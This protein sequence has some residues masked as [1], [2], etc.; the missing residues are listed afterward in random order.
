MSSWAALAAELA[1]WRAE[2]RMATF[3]WRDDDATAPGRAL[4][5]LL[6][7]AA[8][9]RA[10][11]ALAVIPAAAEAT[12]AERL[13]DARVAVLQH[14]YAHANHA[15]PGEKRAELGSHR[16]LAAMLAELAD[17]AR[18]LAELFGARSRPV[19]VPPWNRIDP[20]LVSLLPG[21]AIAGLS[22]YRA[23]TVA[24]PAF[25]LVQVNSH[26]DIVDWRA[27]RFL[28]E[29]AALALA[30]EHLAARRTGRADAEEATGLLT[31][32]AV[33]EPAA[34]RFVERLIAAVRTGGGRWLAAEELF[35]PR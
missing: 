4:D 21:I 31:H 11:V 34:W 8:G 25:G 17:G 6:T 26:V 19:L 33:H 16:P 27:R 9:L 12:L 22:T 3:W 14:G 18:R 1:R 35:V 10:P 5:R 20:G 28:G 23:R 24:S 29:G 15:P 30:V 32:H 7:I 2:G 13:D